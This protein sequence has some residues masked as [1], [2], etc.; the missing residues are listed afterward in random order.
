MSKIIDILISRIEEKDGERITYKSI[1]RKINKYDEDKCHELWKIIQ[2][3]NIIKTKKSE[4][5]PYYSK[6]TSKGV[7]I[8]LKSLP[9]E[10][11]YILNEFTILNDEINS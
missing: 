10:L 4:D 7:E 11:L 3:Y 1:A 6:Q 2:Q 5:L 9:T 8:D